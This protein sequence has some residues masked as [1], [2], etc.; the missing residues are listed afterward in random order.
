MEG[1]DMAG[2]RLTA[3]L[4]AD[5]AGYSALMGAN[6]VETVSAL[7]GHQSVILPMISGYS[8]RVIDTAGDGVLA[9]FASVFNAVKCAVAIQEVVLERNASV[10]PDRRMQY[11]IGINQGDVL[12]DEDRIYGDGT[13]IAARLEGI[14][15]PGGICISG[16][17]YDEIRGRFEIQYED[18]GEQALKNISVPVRTYRIAVSGTSPSDSGQGVKLPIWPGRRGWIAAGVAL[19][20]LFV[21]GAGWWALSPL[22]RTD[23]KPQPSVQAEARRERSEPPPQAVPA[24]LGRSQ[25]A[26]S[27]EPRTAERGAPEKTPSDAES[28]AA[29]IAAATPPSEA[30]PSA[31]MSTGPVKQGFEGVWE[32]QLTGNEHCPIRSRTFRMTFRDGGVYLVSG[33][34]VGGVSSDGSFRFSTPAIANPK[35]TVDSHGKV[36]GEDG[37]GSYKVIG[38][39]CAG[40]YQIR[41]VLKL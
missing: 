30:Q 28:I 35:F 7:K 41:I 9:E 17:V 26:T 39:Q 1:Q 27:V 25:P 14:C 31:S 10:A 12:F 8:G 32:F 37:R 18:I 19:T 22:Q 11:R 6:E 13:N 4:A 21:V 34:K 23:R 40:A 5:I 16:K 24:D 29:P 36:S 20:L 33:Q 38:G 15:Q 3:I 2:R